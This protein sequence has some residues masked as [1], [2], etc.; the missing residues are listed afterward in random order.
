MARKSVE[1]FSRKNNENK[2]GGAK[3]SMK[4]QVKKHAKK[5]MKKRKMG[6]K[7]KGGQFPGDDTYAH[8]NHPQQI[9]VDELPGTIKLLEDREE[10]NQ[11][12]QV[13]EYYISVSSKVVSSDNCI[14]T[15]NVKVS[16]EEVKKINFITRDNKIYDLGGNEFSNH[17]VLIIK[18]FLD[19]GTNIFNQF[20]PKRV[21]GEA[22]YPYST[23][24]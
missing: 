3:K 22:P 5:S 4:K 9:C 14:Y 15:L 16:N 19:N 23:R 1:T 2:T 6:K 8:P 17:N 21:I 7:L 10:L 11:N 20:V 13:N 18:T 12:L 24:P